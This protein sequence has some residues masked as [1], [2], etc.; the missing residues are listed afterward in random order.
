[1]RK[2][3]RESEGTDF[4]LLTGDYRVRIQREI[5]QEASVKTD[6]GK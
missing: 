3:Y 5:R 4:T 6:N 1:M 2:G